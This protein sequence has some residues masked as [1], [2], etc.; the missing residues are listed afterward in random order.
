MVSGVVAAACA[1]LVSRG[2]REP[3]GLLQNRIRERADAWGYRVLP[4]MVFAGRAT[5]SLVLASKM[6]PLN[7]AASVDAPIARLFAFGCQCGR[8][9]KQRRWA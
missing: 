5:G 4:R 9:T 6:N 3:D 2:D 8:A 1:H 7:P